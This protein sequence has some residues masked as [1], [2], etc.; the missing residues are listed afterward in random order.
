LKNLNENTGA[1]YIEQLRALEY[2]IRK[3]IVVREDQ[4]DDV[5]P[6][7]KEKAG[8]HGLSVE[9]LNT[10]G[11]LLNAVQTALRAAQASVNEK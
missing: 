5:D 10:K 7:L 3:S 9:G 1:Q 4:E 11:D 6:W 8:Q 2:E